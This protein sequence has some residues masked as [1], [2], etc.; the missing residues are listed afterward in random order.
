MALYSVFLVRV[1]TIM[2]DVCLCFYHIF[3]IHG[4]EE[5]FAC[6]S[7]LCYCS[8]VVQIGVERYG[9]Y[10]FRGNGSGL[11]LSVCLPSVGRERGSVEG[12]LEHRYQVR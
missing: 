4:G 9:V 2:Y 1:T 3:L 8:G 10:I 5:E 6:L 7:G 12:V 11:L